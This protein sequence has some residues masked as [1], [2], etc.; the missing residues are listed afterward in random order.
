[1]EIT[2][3]FLVTKLHG[4]VVKVQPLLDE[5]TEVDI[6]LD[7]NNLTSNDLA[8]WYSHLATDAREEKIQQTK[9]RG[10]LY[11]TQEAKDLC[12]NLS[13]YNISIQEKVINFE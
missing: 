8:L 3:L 1:M 11:D 13:M 12:C 6:R 7:I 2:A 4:K 9:Q 5:Y 10:Y